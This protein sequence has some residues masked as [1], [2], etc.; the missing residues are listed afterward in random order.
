[1]DKRNLGARTLGRLGGEE[2]ILGMPWEA[3]EILRSMRNYP[4]FFTEE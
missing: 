2:R 1:M 4:L 3:V